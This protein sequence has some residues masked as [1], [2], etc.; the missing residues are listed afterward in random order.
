ML[1]L[2]CDQSA[3]TLSPGQC[4]LGIIKAY[5]DRADCGRVD[6]AIDG[7]TLTLPEKRP[8]AGVWTL[9][10][11]TSCGCFSAPVHI[12]CPAP[13]LRPTHQPTSDTEL[14]IP[15]C[16]PLVEQPEFDGRTVVLRNPAQLVYTDGL[17]QGNLEGVNSGAYKVW[18]AYDENERELG[19]AAVSYSETA[20]TLEPMQVPVKPTWI[21]I[22]P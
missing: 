4:G 17:A 16:C 1:T 5:L 21:R 15:V 9:N 18:R 10:V 3:I 14:P 2:A 12:Q 6:L 20:L 22:E 8:Q 7:E 19:C 13:A 11:Q